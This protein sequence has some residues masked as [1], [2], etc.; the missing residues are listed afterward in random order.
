MEFISAAVVMIGISIILA[1]S[2]NLILGF[3]GLLS[4]AHPAFFALGAYCSAMLSMRLGLPIPL[5]M[6]C[7]V[8]FASLSSLILAIPSLRVSGDYLV[9]ASIGFQL[10]LLQVIKNLEWTGGA[11]GLTGIPSLLP[12]YGWSNLVL[13]WALIGVIA[14]IVVLVIRRMTSGS[15]GRAIAAMRDDEEAFVALGRNA[16]RM[17]ITI[18]AIASG[19]SGLAGV[20]YAHYFVYL[21]PEQFDITMSAAILTMVIVGGVRT[22][23]G[24]IVGAVLLETAP[25]AINILDLPNTMIG[26]LQGMIFTGLVIVFL[27]TRP[28]GIVAAKKA[29][30]FSMR[31]QRAGR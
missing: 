24:P 29:R 10:G 11:G 21:V 22:V 7:G 20:L 15:Y 14:L 31:T 17:K 25:R 28:E 18:F 27:F 16:R 9:I 4:I 6:V 8:L 12:N 3:S 13:Y 26:P 30:D 23:L 19:M 2:F 1:S 5:A